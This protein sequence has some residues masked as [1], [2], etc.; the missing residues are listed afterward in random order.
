MTERRVTIKY[1][2]EDLPGWDVP[3]DESIDRATEL[4]LEDGAVLRVK[5]VVSAVIRV[6]GKTDKDGNPLYVVKA[7]NNISLVSPPTRLKDRKVQ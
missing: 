3:V 2:N 4:R 5:V 7:A 1:N 6:D